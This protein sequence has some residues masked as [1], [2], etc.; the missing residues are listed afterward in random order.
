MRSY[1]HVTTGPVSAVLRPLFIT[2]SGR[3]LEWLGCFPDWGAGHKVIPNA[4]GRARAL[5]LG[6]TKFKWL[7]TNA[8]STV[9][10]SMDDSCEDAPMRG[11]VRHFEQV[12]I[13][14]LF[15]NAD[16]SLLSPKKERV[17]IQLHSAPDPV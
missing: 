11:Y 9:Q 13:M 14:A 17:V 2:S 10:T 8:I 1:M 4:D 15:K 16:T 5:A 3:V 12:H 6:D 7:P